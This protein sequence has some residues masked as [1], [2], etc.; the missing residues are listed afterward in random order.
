MSFAADLEV[1]LEV[2]GRVSSLVEL[3][4]SE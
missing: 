1:I 2:F 4:I 3:A